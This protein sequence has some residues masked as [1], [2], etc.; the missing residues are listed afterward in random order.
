MT[1]Q[2]SVE[3]VSQNVESEWS[4]TSLRMALESKWRPNQDAR[5]SM[6][7]QETCL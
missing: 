6:K 7:P 4:P 3:P 2:E 5:N 1:P